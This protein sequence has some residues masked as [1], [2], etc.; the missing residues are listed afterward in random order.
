MPGAARLRA[1]GWAQRWVVPP[2]S[3]R[4]SHLARPIVGGQR[5]AR[6]R[7]DSKITRTH[8]PICTS[9]AVLNRGP[10]YGESVTGLSNMQVTK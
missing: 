2:S 8:R 6:Q 1:T 3:V 9:F 5:H 10:P 4:Q 7:I